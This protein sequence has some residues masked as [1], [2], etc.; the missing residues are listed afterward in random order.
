MFFEKLIR[1]SDTI[2]VVLLV[3]N[4]RSKQHLDKCKSNYA[5]EKN[6]FEK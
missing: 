4:E 6:N 5:K 3:R 2:S 1:M